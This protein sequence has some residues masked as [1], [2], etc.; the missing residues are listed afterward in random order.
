MGIKIL[1]EPYDILH[2]AWVGKPSAYKASFKA[3]R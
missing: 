2:H 3:L 1:V